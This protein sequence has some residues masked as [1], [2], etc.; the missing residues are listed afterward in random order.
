VIFDNLKKGHRQAVPDAAKLVVGDLADNN[1]VETVFRRQQFDA[2]FHFAALIEAGE[3]MHHPSDYFVNNTSHTIHLLRTLARHKISR[4]IFSSTAAVYG[5]PCK[6]PIEEDHPLN[7]INAYG[8]SKLMVE[9]VLGW[10]HQVHGL[11]FACLRYFNA[12]GAASRDQGEDHQ[13]ESHLIPLTLRVALGQQEE[14]RIFGTDY[15]TPDGTCVRDFVHVSDL[16]TA[17]LLALDALARK[18]AIVCN[19]GNG[20]GFSVREVVDAARQV[21]GRVI[22]TSELRRRPGDPPILVASSEAAKRELGWKPQIASL[23]DIV[24]TAWEWHREHPR[25]YCS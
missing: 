21:T 25:G 4:F 24:A 22:R 10:M 1:A 12:A 13:P 20:R 3:S 7:P 18:G 15:P 2:V 6:L 5:D 14:I 9:Q 8:Q 17:H 19:L 23:A 11:R 16:A